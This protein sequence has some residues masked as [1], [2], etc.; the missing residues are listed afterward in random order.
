MRVVPM[1]PG[2]LDQVAAI[3]A[4]AG[5]VHWTRDQFAKELQG[6]FRRFFV[7]VEDESPDVLAYGG[8]WKA[9]PEAQITNLVVRP[10]S[11]CRG[12]GRR[13]L[14]FIMDCARGESCSVCTLEVRQSNR[15]AQSLYKAAGFQVKGQRPKIYQNPVDDALLMEKTL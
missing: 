3:E 5:D 2:H 7:V 10:E 15:H 6:E 8:Y 1:E 12:I 14:E 11:R 9:G 4:C 13:I